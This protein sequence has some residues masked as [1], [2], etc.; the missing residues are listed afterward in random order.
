MFEF[1]YLRSFSLIV[2]FALFSGIDGPPWSISKQF[3]N[4]V[5]VVS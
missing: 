3:G 5:G 1:C 2:L 4:F